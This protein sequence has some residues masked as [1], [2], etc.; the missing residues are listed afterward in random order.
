MK[1]SGSWLAPQADKPDTWCSGKQHTKDCTQI[2]CL[3]L[4][5]KGIKSTT[6]QV[7]HCPKP[8]WQRTL[9]SR[10]EGI[11]WHPQQL[12]HLEEWLLQLQKK[13]PFSNCLAKCSL[14]VC[15]PLLR[16]RK[17]RFSCH[18]IQQANPAHNIWQ[19]W[20]D[21]ST[22]LP[23]VSVVPWHCRC[24]AEVSFCSSKSDPRQP[25]HVHP[26]QLLGQNTFS[27]QSC[28]LLSR[29]ILGETF[30]MIYPVS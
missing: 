23:S 5:Y 30:S 13:S 18:L 7:P 2:L 6:G 15:F 8:T 14:L 19:T 10:K 29:E 3:L 28:W 17:R 27:T 4:L 1:Y 11:L 26:L 24:K 25:V 21:W 9:G 20:T 16:I 22:K 12:H